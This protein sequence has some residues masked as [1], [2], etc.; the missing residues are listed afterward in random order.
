MRSMRYRAVSRSNWWSNRRSWCHEPRR[1]TRACGGADP[2][3]VNLSGVYSGTAARAPRA[4]RV[5]LARLAARRRIRARRD[6]HESSPRAARRPLCVSL[7]VCRFSVSVQ[8][9]HARAARRNLTQRPASYP[10]SERTKE[11]RALARG[12]HLGCFE[13]RVAG[14]CVAGRRA[15]SESA[16]LRARPWRA[17]QLLSRPTAREVDVSE[18]ICD[19]CER[20]RMS[21]LVH[22]ERARTARVSTGHACE[23]PRGHAATLCRFTTHIYACCTALR[24]ASAGWP[25]AEPLSVQRALPFLGRYPPPQLSR[26]APRAHPRSFRASIRSIS[27]GVHRVRCRSTAQRVALL[28]PLSSDTLRQDAVHV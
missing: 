3:T 24:F 1:N 28:V 26:S 7:L 15:A 19:I 21:R 17:A 14:N 6:A 9:S 18:L 20:K 2:A 23:G 22:S 11:V 5:P 8:I 12:L 13:R 25:H 4:R 27:A 16:D 10:V